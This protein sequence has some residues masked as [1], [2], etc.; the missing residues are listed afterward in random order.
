MQ[1]QVK[2][3]TFVLKTVP[4]FPCHLLVDPW[5]PTGRYSTLASSLRETCCCATSNLPLGVTNEGREAIT[6]DATTNVTFRNISGNFLLYVRPPELLT[7]VLLHL[8]A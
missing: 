2:E 5:S 8:G 6:L 7:I 3:A 1:V 4:L